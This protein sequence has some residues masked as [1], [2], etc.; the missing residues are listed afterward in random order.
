MSEI[1]TKPSQE[2]SW[3]NRLKEE[4]WEAELLVSAVAIFAVLKG[5][6]AVDWLV[7]K[8]IDNLDPSQYFVG[9][10]VVVSGYLAI[11]VL[12]CMF[13]I[14]F[15]LRAY[16]IGLV[17]LNSV[18]PDYSLEDSA[19]SPIY[20][21]K[22]LQILPKLPKTINKVDE[23]CS[24]IF[25][26]AF[27]LMMVYLYI[28]LVAT[29]YLILYNVLSDLVPHRILLIPAYILGLIYIIGVSIS[30]P[31][32]MKRNHQKK[33][34]QHIFFLYS[35]FGNKILLGPLYKNIMQV[36]MIFGSNFKKK[37][38]LV[39]LVIFMG[40]VGVCFG[41][42]RMSQSDYKYLILG[43]E[44]RDSTR[45]ENSFYANM[46]TSD[47]LL[48][49]EIQSDII[50]TKGIKLFIPI[51][52]HEI[53]RLSEVC[54]LK[55]YPKFKKLPEDE[56]Q[57]KREEHLNCYHEK[58]KISIDEKVMAVEFIK[59][60]H[61]VTQQFGILTYMTSDDLKKGMHKLKVEKTLSESKKISWEI[62]FFIA[63][64]N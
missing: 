55:T 49:P 33:R 39:R 15:A 22:L 50:D 24:V 38:S 3:L 44:N 7:I 28:T 61:P 63:E 14:H 35:G 1:E 5:F 54:D 6:S 62:P 48:T 59:A 10:T 43:L 16:W 57:K 21:E 25:S 29:L 45:V 31:A 40:V 30:I 20:T 51:M 19:Y 42:V 53:R 18:F 60:D 36:F 56:R 34:L 46:N 58:H 41:G 13:I 9:Y 2:K 27:S 11:G 37:K 17:G 47:F 52:E 23:L 8:F 26:A 12:A 4:S 64:T 32:S